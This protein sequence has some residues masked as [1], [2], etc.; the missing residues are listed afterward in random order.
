MAVKIRL[1]RTGKRGRPMKNPPEIRL[2]NDRLNYWVKFGAKP[3]KT[4]LDIINK[5]K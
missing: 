1:S 4:V 2:D 5:N 3:T